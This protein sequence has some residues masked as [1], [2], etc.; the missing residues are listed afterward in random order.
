MHISY[1]K[2]SMCFGKKINNIGFFVS[3]L[4]HFLE[5]CVK[6]RDWLPVIEMSYFITHRE[7]LLTI[8]LWK[9]PY[10]FYDS[11]LEQKMFIVLF[12]VF[13]EFR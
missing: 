11:Y 9:C 5:K 12:F 4:F 8:Y 13:S 6:R 2:D 1:T 10:K 3:S 7:Q